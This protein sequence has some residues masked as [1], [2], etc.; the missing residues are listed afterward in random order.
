MK[1]VLITSLITTSIVFSVYAQSQPVTDNFD[2]TE[3]ECVSLNYN[4]S[5]RSR[6]AVTGGEVSLLQ[7]FLS[8]LY[9]SGEPTGFFGRATEAAVKRFQS[10]YGLDAVGRV[11]ALTRAK[12]KAVSCGATQTSNIKP[13]QEANLQTS[14]FLT[15]EAASPVSSNGAT[16]NAAAT[17]GDGTYSGYFLYSTNTAPNIPTTST[18]FQSGGYQRFS[19]AITNLMPNT[20]YYYQARA[21][22]VVTGQEISGN[23]LSF[24]TKQ[25]VNQA[26]L[27]QCKVNLIYSKKIDGQTSSDL[28]IEVDNLN[29]SA[30]DVIFIAGAESWNSLM[31]TPV[32]SVQVGSKTITTIKA[33]QSI[34][35]QGISYIL[36]RKQAIRPTKVGSK[37]VDCATMAP[38]N[39][40]TLAPA[41]NIVVNQITNIRANEKYELFSTVISNLD[42]TNQPRSVLVTLDAPGSGVFKEV[43]LVENGT[44]VLD[45]KS[46]LAG[47]LIFTIPQSDIASST[48]NLSIV[49]YTE[50]QMK[51]YYSG[52]LMQAVFDGVALTNNTTITPPGG[53]K[54]GPK[55]SIVIDQAVATSS[56]ISIS[57]QQVSM[58]PSQFVVGGTTQTLLSLLMQNQTPAEAVIRELRFA[59]DGLNAIQSIS[60]QGITAPVILGKATVSGLSIPVTSSVVVPITVTYSG[61][62]NSSSGGT[63]SRSVDSVS[64]A[65]VGAE[66]I[67]R[68]NNTVQA[69]TLS[70]LE[71]NRM[72]L[73]ASRP[74]F[75]IPSR[76]SAIS[77]N[78]EGKIADVSVVADPNGKIAIKTLGMMVS[79]SG[80]SNLNLSAI[81]VKDTSSDVPGVSG[82]YVG[83]KLTIT[84]GNGG[85]E[86]APGTAKTLSV[87]AMVEGSAFASIAPY[88]TTKLDPS[89]TIWIDSLGGYTEQTSNK[90]FGFPQNATVIEIVAPTQT[91]A[92]SPSV[93][94]VQAKAASSGEI[95]AGES[96]YVYGKLF[97]TKTTI[98]L[99]G[100]SG[101]INISPSVIN[102]G[103]MTFSVPSFFQA[104]AYTVVAKDSLTN[105]KSA[106]FTVK[107]LT[108]SQPVVK[109]CDYAA[110]PEGCTWVTGPSYNQSTGCG[111]ELS[112]QQNTQNTKYFSPAF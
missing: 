102:D 112:C 48:R 51:S 91:T 46:G 24:V 2:T 86:I 76:V 84:F 78:Q 14:Q 39:V 10:A 101:S 23:T 15:T 89:S 108:A 92:P 26:D 85:Y 88:I 52:M 16:L 13:T 107:L 36:E 87:Y 5:Y 8:P 42:K 31:F 98:L 50:P 81:K 75:A 22:N 9:L 43:A 72:I 73:V 11:G 32:S 61:F 59:T 90:L 83:G 54:F 77:L 68:S 80:V 38:I 33:T 45:S 65:L 66:S 69:L 1:K 28:Y 37:Q 105:A 25:D 58:P 49:A 21:K 55:M 62:M 60:V 18:I 94:S 103:L 93:T 96:A 7:D 56:P 97:S 12:I 74:S 106:P 82:S 30:S 79:P 63:L 4:L 47:Q 3:T 95:Y 35:A 57:L 27:G 110:P 17:I 53:R 111:M 44:K 104:G 99:E 71:S 67:L 109:M 64:V 20:L 34:N 100:Q 6:D 19:A 40:T 70:P 29:A 41:V